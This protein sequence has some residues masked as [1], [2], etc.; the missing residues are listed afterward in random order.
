MMPGEMRR[1]QPNTAPVG[2][3][4]VLEDEIADN[5]PLYKGNEG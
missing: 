2:D 5:E 1:E 3:G 4:R